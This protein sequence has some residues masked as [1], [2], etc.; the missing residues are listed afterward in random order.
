[1]G[2]DGVWGGGGGGWRGGGEVGMM[3]GGFDQ[4]RSVAPRP[5]CHPSRGVQQR[6]CRTAVSVVRG[7][8]RSVCLLAVDTAAAAAAASGLTDRCV[9]CVTVL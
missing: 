2:K 9:P 8:T 5:I 6:S 1:M 7:A 3:G 4:K